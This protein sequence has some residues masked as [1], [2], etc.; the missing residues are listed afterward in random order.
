MRQQV[1]ERTGK[2][3]EEHLLDGGYLR[4]EDLEE[5]HRQKVKLYIP[6]KPARDP[7]KRG[8]ELEIKPGDSEAVREWKLRMASEE[9]KNIYKQRAATSETVNG[10]L[11]TY[12]GLT[13]IL[14][15]GLAKDRCVALWC[16]LAYNVMH[17]GMKLLQ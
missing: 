7:N 10:D 11:R 15:R 12:R 9:G 17:F 16:A 3:V 6:P 14:V 5:G 4:M 2:K 1:E 13:Q 8:H